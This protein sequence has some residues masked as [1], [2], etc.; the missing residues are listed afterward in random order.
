MSST[1]ND[2]SPGQRFGRVLTLISLAYAAV[3]LWSWGAGVG[4]LCSFGAG[5]FPTAP[6]TAIGLAGFGLVLF[7]TRPW[8]GVVLGMHWGKVVMTLLSGGGMLAM[9]RA[10]FGWG[11]PVERWLAQSNDQLGNMPVGLMSSLTGALFLVAGVTYWLQATAGKKQS[12][13]WRAGQVLAVGI[14]VASAGMLAGYAGKRPWIYGAAGVP[15]SLGTAGAFYLLGC[16]LFCN[17]AGFLHPLPVEA[18][19]G[20]RLVPD[21]GFNPVW[22]VITFVF[23]ISTLTAVYHRHVQAQDR[24]DAR[25]LLDAVGKLKTAQILDWR[26]ERLNDA[27]FFAQADFVARDVFDLLEH[28][29]SN[30]VRHQL[31]SL[32]EGLKGGERFAAV[33]FFDTNGV[34]RL[35]LPAAGSAS[36]MAR[37]ALLTEAFRRR[38]VIMSDLYR[39]SEGDRVF[40]D[41]VLPIMEPEPTAGPLGPRVEPP[42]IGGILLRLDPHQALFPLVTAWPTRSRTSEAMLYRRNGNQLVCLT[43]R[44]LPTNAPI[45]FATEPVLNS[46]QPAITDFPLR[47]GLTEGPDY[48]G[49]PVFA[50]ICQIPDSDWF[51]LVKIDREEVCRTLYHQA[52]LTLL[53]TLMLALASGTALGFVSKRR[54]ARR[55][56]AVLKVE[57]ERHALAQR[58]EHLMRYANDAILLADQDFHIVEANDRL[59]KTYDYS[60]AQIRTMSI[61]DLRAPEA[62]DG[63]AEDYQRLQTSRQ[64]V[65]ETLHQ[66]RDGSIFPVE[67]S[68]NLVEIDG[69]LFKLAI[70][71][72]ISERKAQEREI[73][74]LARLYD[75]LSQVNQCIVRVRSREE[76]F[77]EICRITVDHA[78]FK[79]VWIGWRVPGTEAIEI[80]ARAGER[81][82][83]LSGRDQIER[84]RCSGGKR[85]GG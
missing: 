10:W 42:L 61:S 75:T 54:D 83:G 60:L 47:L 12:V 32:L 67:V 43:E 34:M 82:G 76:L 6:S 31:R 2:F 41:I 39:T 59:L 62:R 21:P 69:S 13:R 58:V 66:R 26:N 22:I 3:V 51:L 65:F 14:M 72:D 16:A 57:Q 11:S 52:W 73:S 49:V 38:Q 1:T 85:A 37:P 70:I 19:A 46:S 35:G 28:P 78:G 53:L 74:R 48:R 15:V 30:F 7:L 80:L 64:A 84:R 77:A 63:F 44:R 36:L 33:A 23:A 20:S 25:G 79:V 40:L 27:R 56:L 55:A 68:S 17:A 50:D 24:K 45:R 5:Q 71:R 8:P 81:A 4:Y 9:L 18:P 29:N